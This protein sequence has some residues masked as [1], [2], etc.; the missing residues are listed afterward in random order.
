MEKANN[1]ASSDWREKTMSLVRA[2]IRQADPEVVEEVKWKK[3]SHPAGIP[4]WYH[5]GMI[6]T[7]ETYQNHLRLTFA[8]GSTL[9]GNDPKGLFNTFRAITIHEGDKIDET[10]FKDIIRAAVALNLLDKNQNLR[11]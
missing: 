4:V 5:G 8:K 9:R 10:A 6:C 2:L 11:R 1:V 7:G 3:P